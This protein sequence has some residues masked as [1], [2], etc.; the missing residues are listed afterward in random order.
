A[1]PK[2]HVGFR[3]KGSLAPK[4]PGIGCPAPHRPAALED[5][6]LETRLCENERRKQSAGTKS[7]H[8]RPLANTL[9]GSVPDGVIA[10]IRGLFDVRVARETPQNGRLVTGLQ[11]DDVDEQDGLVFLTRVVAS[12]E[13]VE[14]QQVGVADLKSRE[15]R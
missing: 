11:V 12:L 13:Y 2:L 14:F 10:R 1:L 9:S 4:S 5:N 6:R 15:N 7:Y 8:E 3:R